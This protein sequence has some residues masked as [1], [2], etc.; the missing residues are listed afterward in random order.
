MSDKIQLPTPG[1]AATRVGR[2]FRHGNVPDVDEV[3]E[4]RM[5]LA[6]ARIDKEI[7]AAMAGSPIPLSPA[8]VGHLVGL[9]MMRGGTDEVA[10]ER[11]ARAIREALYV[12]D[13]LTDEDRATLAQMVLGGK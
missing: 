6:A 1:A 4:A 13:A 8:Y 3:S 7:R 2:M 5:T 11:C 10:V 9:L 12:T